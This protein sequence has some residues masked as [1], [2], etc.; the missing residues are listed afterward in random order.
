MA[1]T[2]SQIQA[3]KKKLHESFA[4]TEKKLNDT[5]AKQMAKI[6]Y[7]PGKAQA[8]LAAAREANKRRE[9]NVASQAAKKAKQEANKTAVDKM[10]DRQSTPRQRTE[11]D[12]AVSA[13][14]KARRNT[15]LAEFIN[16]VLAELKEQNAIEQFIVEAKKLESAAE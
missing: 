1:K 15:E 3:E 7:T 8:N 6:G 14:V 5:H 4:P 12:E 10:W 2:T 11:E 16:G 13:L 9:Q